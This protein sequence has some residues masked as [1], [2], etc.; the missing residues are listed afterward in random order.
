MNMKIHKL[1]LTSLVVF[2][3]LTSCKTAYE[4]VLQGNDADA[5]YDMAFDYFNKGKYSKAA[6]LFESL[7]QLSEGTARDD[8]V[9]FYWGLSNYRFKDY[10]TAETNLKDFF[11]TFPM[12]P[13][14]EEARFLQIDCLYKSTNRYEL[15]QTPSN[16]ALAAISSY[17]TDYPMTPRLDVCM[18]MIDDLSERM[19]RKAYENAKLY[20][21]MEDYLAAR[22]ALKNVLKD[23]AENQYR[24]DIMYYTAMASYK[25]AYL[26][27]PEKQKER[28][29]VFADDYFSF[30]G[31]FPDSGY[32]HTVDVL[33]KRSQK[34]LGRFVGSGE[35]LELDNKKI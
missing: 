18:S 30:I 34:A 24:E 17:L 14:T 7:S 3:S 13:F 25:Y 16:T 2:C 5:K 21:K 33:Y 9:R 11:K 15:D 35:E 4:V 27:V 29:L 1:I 12:S 20:Y 10:F 6:Q 26:S 32:R 8:T 23:D 19:D 28:Y 22:V 31:E